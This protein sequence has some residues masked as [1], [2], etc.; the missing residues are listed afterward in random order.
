M[1]SRL[2]IAALTAVA[3]TGCATR[4]LWA[5]LPATDAGIAAATA[6][7]ETRYTLADGRTVSRLGA[8]RMGGVICPNTL[9]DGCIRVADIRA[10]EARTKETDVGRSLAQAPLMPLALGLIAPVALL[11]KPAGPAPDWIADPNNSCVKPDDPARVAGLPAT[12]PAALDYIWAERARLGGA[13]LAD[14]ATGW[15]TRDAAKAQEL[16]LL[17]VARSA[18]EAEQCVTPGRAATTYG[19][20]RSLHP[21]PG[22]LGPAMPTDDAWIARLRAIVAD[23][24]AVSSEVA[25]ELV[26]APA[27]GLRAIADRTG[28]SL[29]VA[30][31]IA[32]GA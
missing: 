23:P 5:P 26:C 17:G 18:F 11:Q 2:I 10:V 15:A 4:D 1:W 29:R 14:A 31:R 22:A 20:A 21:I 32:G 27:G 16:Y 3:V 30:A 25:L 24:T 7:Y 12:T 19:R 9:Y 28:A 13:C 8:R 6:R